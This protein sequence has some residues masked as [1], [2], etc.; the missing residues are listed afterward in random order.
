MLLFLVNMPLSLIHLPVIFLTIYWR[1][2][3]L[4]RSK[5]TCTNYLSFSVEIP[6]TFSLQSHEWGGKQ[7]IFIQQAGTSM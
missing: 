1:E 3:V 7:K 2:N 5:L 4:K 6:K